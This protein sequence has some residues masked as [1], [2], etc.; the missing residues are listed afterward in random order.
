MIQLNEIKHYLSALTKIRLVIS[1]TPGYGDQVNALNVI[2][3]IQ[4]LGFTG[5][6]EAVYYGED[7]SRKKLK[8]LLNL[9]NT[10][11]SD[12]CFLPEKNLTLVPMNYFFKHQEKFEQLPLTVAGGE[13]V[14]PNTNMA[15]LWKTDV[16]IEISPYQTSHIGVSIREKF[17]TTLYPDTKHFFIPKQVT[18][19][20]TLKTIIPTLDI[21]NK[22]FWLDLITRLQQKSLI[23][24]SVYGLNYEEA[25]V[26]FPREIILLNLMIAAHF[27]QTHQAELR[28]KPLL[29]LVHHQQPASELENLRQIISGSWPKNLTKPSYY[30]QILSKVKN[31]QL[32]KHIGI[33]DINSINLETITHRIVVI[34]TGYL[35]RIVFDYLMSSSTLPAIQEGKNSEDFFLQLGKPF[36]QATFSN[37]LSL[38]ANSLFQ[39]ST[40][41]AEKAKACLTPSDDLQQ[42]VWQHGP[43][44]LLGQYTVELLKPENLNRLQQQKNNYQTIDNNKVIQAF[45]YYLMNIK[46]GIS[47]NR[48]FNPDSMTLYGSKLSLSL[49]N[50]N[51]STAKQIE[52][53][54]ESVHLLAMR[55]IPTQWKFLNVNPEPSLIVENGY[56]KVQPVTSQLTPVIQ[57]HLIDFDNLKNKIFSD[58]RKTAE[59]IFFAVALDKHDW[60]QK[61]LTMHPELITAKGRWSLLM[62]A[63]AAKSQKMIKLLLS[64]GATFSHE[65][66]I[67][68][69]QYGNP[70]L[71]QHHKIKKLSLA[72]KVNACIEGDNLANFEY[73]VSQQPENKPFVSR[74][75]FDNT[76]S[77]SLL[78]LA[79]LM[80]P[81][82]DDLENS[83][84]LAVIFHLMNRKYT[85]DE[86]WLCFA[87][88]LMQRGAILNS[89][90]LPTIKHTETAVLLSAYDYT[91]E[92]GDINNKLFKCQTSQSNY[93]FVSTHRHE[94]HFFKSL[95]D[96]NNQ[97]ETCFVVR[98][99]NEAPC[100]YTEGGTNIISSTGDLPEAMLLPKCQLPPPEEQQNF[101][102]DFFITGLQGFAL[103]FM[104]T[105]LRFYFKPLLI[106]AGL[107]NYL[108]EIIVGVIDIFIKAMILSSSI[109]PIAIINFTYRLIDHFLP[110]Q[111]NLKRIINSVQTGLNLFL[112]S[113]NWPEIFS[114]IVAYQAG[115]KA[116]Q[117]II[118]QLPKLKQEENFFKP[119]KLNLGQ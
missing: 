3:E 100:Y 23:T 107:K 36:L 13:F 6:I 4:R 73:L 41:L 103:G 81:H 44:N 98:S 72:E 56:L 61:A 78:E 15:T 31:L 10:L 2:A 30:T 71:I 102:N 85:A 97:P 9:P 17:A 115:V 94:P 70:I 106:N 84:A 48:L 95:A 77:F 105:L 90:L 22:N 80:Q 46:P 47:K 1:G 108:A 8:N 43:E 27:T 119:A 42:L 14:Y 113:K 82:V 55:A 21:V 19:S 35:P 111:T 110:V 75:Q 24:Q 39:K 92:S 26:K 87:E 16:F 18:N 93:I 52:Q 57:S 50:G 53:Q 40:H 114:G 7:H 104:D 112:N 32:Q 76:V 79:Q 88:S 65:D 37:S 60:V 101:I 89:K 91:Y 109:A 83:K 54:Y 64:A 96:K 45:N 33:Y 86:A 63:I 118:Q 29:L 74:E 11:P 59:K 28:Q 34:S 5:T 49:I 58:K 25:A 69:W 12:V 67:Q 116:G 66:H 68:L 51:P 38:D 117:L 62:I 20:S 99:I